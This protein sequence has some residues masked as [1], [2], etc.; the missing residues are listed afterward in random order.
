MALSLD[1]YLDE[2]RQGVEAAL[3]R[4]V[5]ELASVLPDQW[6]EPAEAGVLSGGKRL[7]PCLLIAAGEAFGLEATPPFYDLGCIRGAD[8]CL[9]V[10]A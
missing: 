3:G 1:D 7:R 5:S 8:P 2:R 9:L 4:A 10:D 6:R